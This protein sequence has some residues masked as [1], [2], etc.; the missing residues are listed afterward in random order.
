VAVLLADYQPPNEDLEEDEDFAYAPV[1]RKDTSQPHEYDRNL[2]DPMIIEASMTIGGGGWG[3]EN[4]EWHG[5][6]G[7]KEADGVTDDLVVRG[8]ITEAVRGVVGLID[9]DGFLKKY[10]MDE[11]LLEGILPGDIWLRGK[12]VPP[13]AGMSIAPQIRLYRSV[14]L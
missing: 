9:R 14:N 13:P 5:Y 10:Y 4:V 2:P 6:G 1:G 11:R 7:R 8:S 12:Y 3:A